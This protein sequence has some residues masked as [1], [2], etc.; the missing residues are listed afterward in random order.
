VLPVISNEAC[1]IRCILQRTV[2]VGVSDSTVEPNEFRKIGEGRSK[3]KSSTSQPTDYAF[4]R[5]DLRTKVNSTATIA[6]TPVMTKA[7][8]Y[9]PKKSTIGPATNAPVIPAIP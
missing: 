3:E 8:K 4:L 7:Q 1:P 9:E 2:S 5:L 6:R